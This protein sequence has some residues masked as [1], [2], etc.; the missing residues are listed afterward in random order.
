ME[1]IMALIFVTGIA[2]HLAAWK[3][4][5]NTKKKMFCISCEDNEVHIRVLLILKEA[6]VFYTTMPWSTSQ[7]ALT[8]PGTQAAIELWILRKDREKA[9]NSLLGEFQ[10]EEMKYCLRLT[11]K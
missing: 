10:V 3:Y 5:S 9:K 4:I 6:N 11:K 8:A 2:L 1:W 7:E